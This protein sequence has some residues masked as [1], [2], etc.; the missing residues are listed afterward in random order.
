MFTRDVTAPTV[1]VRLPSEARKATGW[2]REGGR[3]EGRSSCTAWPGTA[4]GGR[5]VTVLGRT[6][7]RADGRTDGRTDA[8]TPGRERGDLLNRMGEGRAGEETG[9]PTAA[10]AV[11]AACSVLNPNAVKA[12]G[13]AGGAAAPTFGNDCDCGGGGTL[14]FSIEMAKPRASSSSTSGTAGPELTTFVVESMLYIPPF[15][16]EVQVVHLPPPARPAAAELVGRAERPTHFGRPPKDAG[17][18]ADVDGVDGRT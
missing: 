7:A 9:S 1:H 15:F 8:L 16:S 12:I 4:A 11:A 13:G 3:E 14:G 17:G 18:S 5:P 2:Q 6:H 10:A